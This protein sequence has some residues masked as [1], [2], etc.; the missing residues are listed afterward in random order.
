MDEANGGDGGDGGGGGTERPEYLPEKFWDADSGSANVEALA[1]SYTGLEKKVS[2]DRDSMFKEF[3]TGR[4][5]GRP[6]SAD[7]YQVEVSR[8]EIGL[9][10][11]VDFN[12]DEKDP[13]LDWWKETAH[14]N[15]YTNEQF[16]IGIN[17]YLKREFEGMPNLDSERADLGEN[18][19]A[20]INRV[21][22][23][24]RKTAGDE[25]FNDIQFAM[26]NAKSVMFLEKLMRAGGGVDMGSGDSSIPG[27]LTR[28]E[29]KAMQDDPRY[30]KTQD[31]AYVD[32][33]NN[34]WKQL[35][36]ANKG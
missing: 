7:L 27:K 2:A 35:G 25:L 31:P 36:E 13:L 32:K 16:N 33:V 34:A 26:G 10:E 12:L 18:A 9:P 4:M 21:E 19:Q 29:V 24:A 11:G 20:R 5:S 23:W 3:E 15:G 14:S 1:N 17:K 8:E 28:A 6:E 22:L 30:W